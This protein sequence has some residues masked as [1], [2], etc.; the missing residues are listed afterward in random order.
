VTNLLH[1]SRHRPGNSQVANIE[2]IRWKI[3]KREHRT[4]TIGM[5]SRKIET[6]RCTRT[7]RH[8]ATP[9]RG[10][11]PGFWQNRINRVTRYF[12]GSR[13]ETRKYY[14]RNT[15]DKW[16]GAL[17]P[18][19]LSPGTGPC[20]ERPW[21]PN[22]CLFRVKGTFADGFELSLTFSTL[23]LFGLEVGWCEFFS[24]LHEILLT[25][26]WSRT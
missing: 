18:C 2:H 10:P 26:L 22:N 4:R 23:G 16:K 9:P 13:Y 5:N 15:G 3:Q 25:K 17:N 6:A 8:S 1:S 21:D 20:N 11:P 19:I 14:I 7:E 24:M 12:H